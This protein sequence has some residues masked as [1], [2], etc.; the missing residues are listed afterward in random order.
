M[1]SLNEMRFSLTRIGRAGCLA[2]T[3]ILIS[4]Q[5]S[6]FVY[7]TAT[8]KVDYDLDQLDPKGV[9]SVYWTSAL[10]GDT[11]TIKKIS[12]LPN[13]TMLWDCPPR[14]AS[15]TSKGTFHDPS[16]IDPEIDESLEK[17]VN[18]IES[19]L[20][21][22]KAIRIARRD[23]ASSYDLAEYK[24]FGS[25]ARL[26]FRPKDSPNSTNSTVFFLLQQG[27]R[28]RIVDIRSESQLQSVGNKKFG[29]PRTCAE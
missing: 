28:W 24:S 14:P 18:H 19:M 21:K 11:D 20:L 8:P 7:S 6:C 9:V 15:T 25:E 26:L 23:L 22:A 5:L 12:G 27:G 3:A 1:T 29:E 10:T 4:Y 2:G 13:Q 16:M 17:P